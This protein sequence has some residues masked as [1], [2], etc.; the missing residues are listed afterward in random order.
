MHR[1]RFPNPC[2]SSD[3]SVLR[4]VNEG[5]FPSD[6]AHIR[7]DRVD[8]HGRTECAHVPRQTETRDPGEMP[9][10]PSLSGVRLM[11]GSMRCH[12]GTFALHCATDPCHV[13]LSRVHRG[14]VCLLSP[15]QHHMHMRDAPKPRMPIDA[16]CRCGCYVRNGGPLRWIGGVMPPTQ[17]HNYRLMCP[18][19]WRSSQRTRCRIAIL[20]CPHPHRPLRTPTHPKTAPRCCGAVCSSRMRMGQTCMATHAT[21]AAS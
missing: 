2:T 5:G 17:V 13:C 10:A 7:A 6:R 15:V 8:K 19:P 12:H 14:A 4:W 21:L 18:R 20:P 9:I 16:S 3:C 1:S 11:Y